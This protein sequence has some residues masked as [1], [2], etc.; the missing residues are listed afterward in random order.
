M[1][2]RKITCEI[3]LAPFTILIDGREK[4]P[5]AFHGLRA[6]ADHARCPIVVRCAWAHLPTG[7]Y[8]IQ[9]HEREVAIE[10]KSLADLYSTLGQHRERFE[11]EHERLSHFDFGAVV[12][13]ATWDQILYHPPEF[14]LLLPKTVFRTFC[15]WTVRY[16]VPW[17]P[18]GSRRGAEVMTYRLLE[19][20][21]REKTH[22]E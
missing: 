22:V 18:A 21:W 12:I 19:K 16:H 15:S 20:W 9:G 4:T 14:S 13:E 11:T 3:Q 17:F 5:Y 1:T 7:D 8:S 10:R 2:Q 6:D